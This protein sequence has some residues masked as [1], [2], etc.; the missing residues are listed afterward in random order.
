M[1]LT[2]RSIRNPG[3]DWYGCKG[4]KGRAVRLSS[5]LLQELFRCERW[6]RKSAIVTEVSGDDAVG[7]EGDRSRRLQ[8][9]LGVVHGERERLFRLACA[10]GGDV[11]EAQQLLEKRSSIRADEIRDVRQRV[12]RD[13]D[14]SWSVLCPF[15]DRGR[16]TP[17]RFPF[18]CNVNQNRSL[19]RSNAHTD[20]GSSIAISKPANIKVRADGTVKA[21]DF[22]LAKAMHL[23]GGAQEFSITSIQ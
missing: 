17:E 5:E 23:A 21:L 8:R 15:D 6:H 7:A 12:P 10:D 19:T 9:I 3:A 2:A 22:G 11:D 16:R 14:L 1:T 20:K 18:Q 4:R 13:R